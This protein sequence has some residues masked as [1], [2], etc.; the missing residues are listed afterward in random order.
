MDIG[1]AAEFVRQLSK[2]N[3]K[4]TVV[5]QQKD[6]DRVGVESTTSFFRHLLLDCLPLTFFGLHQSFFVWLLLLDRGLKRPNRWRPD[7]SELCR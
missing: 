3:S 1:I 2:L 7:N 6:M 4:Y 5:V